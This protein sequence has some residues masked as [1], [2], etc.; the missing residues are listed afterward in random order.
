MSVERLAGLLGTSAAVLAR[1]VE[2]ILVHRGLVRVTRCG[3][4]A[5]RPPERSRRIHA[6]IIRIV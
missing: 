5:I 3:R 1:S 4:E 6:G 2:P